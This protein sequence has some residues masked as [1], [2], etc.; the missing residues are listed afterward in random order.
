[1]NLYEKYQLALQLR[2]EARELL[3][4]REFDLELAQSEWESLQEDY[5]ENIFW[6]DLQNDIRR[7]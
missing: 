7:S 4:R 1:M 5:N 6:E 2:D 3:R